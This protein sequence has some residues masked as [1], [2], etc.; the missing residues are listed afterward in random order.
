MKIGPFRY[1]S[2]LLLVPFRYHSGIHFSLYE[3]EIWNGRG[4]GSCSSLFLSWSFSVSDRITS[5][6]FPSSWQVNCFIEIGSFIIH[7]QNSLF[8]ELIRNAISEC[9]NIC[10]IANSNYLVDL[11]LKHKIHRDSCS[12]KTIGVKHLGFPYCN[13]CSVQSVSGLKW[14]CFQ[15]WQLVTFL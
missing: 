12:Y 9:Q 2:A 4:R 15:S 14:N 11:K 6:S 5:I 13:G 7:W 1:H 8:T 10:I 3:T